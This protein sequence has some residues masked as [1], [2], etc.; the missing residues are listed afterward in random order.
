MIKPLISNHE[1]IGT[2]YIGR[3]TAF[4][5]LEQRLIAAIA[6][7]AAN[8]IRRDS[9]YHDLQASTEGLSRAY[10]VTLAGWAKALELRDKET[11]GHSQRVT[12]ITVQLAQK[13]GFTER[14][15]VQLRRGALLHDI[16]KMGI[17]DAILHKPGPLSNEEWDI[18]RL[19]PVYAYDLLKEIDFLAPALDIPYSHHEKWDGTGYPRGLKGKEI[20]L[21]ARI[22]AIVDVWDAL[23]SDRPYRGPWPGE[24]VRAYL[25]EQSGIHFDPDVV[26]HFMAL[27]SQEE[28]I[29]LLETLAD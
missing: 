20:P 5:R 28:S 1:H 11:E 17:P 16:G 4:S 2:L 10:D 29:Q 27:I 21:A 6:D 3:E 9:L 18:M 19:H 13:M 22:F 24:K 7:M 12:E 25:L 8:A 26:R 23:L 14:E 15:I